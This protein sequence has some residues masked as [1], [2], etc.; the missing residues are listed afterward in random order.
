MKKSL[1]I[2][3]F[4]LTHY[5]VTSQFVQNKKADY[6][7]LMGYGYL[8]DSVNSWKYDFNYNPMQYSSKYKL[9][10]GEF[11]TANISDKLGNLIFQ[12]NNC[13]ISDAENKIIQG[14]DTLNNGI[15]YTA[16]CNPGYG[17]SPSQGTI[18]IPSMTDDTSYFMFHQRMTYYID[19]RVG[20]WGVDNLLL[21]K[22]I[23]TN[24]KYKVVFKDSTILDYKKD[25]ILI[26][27]NLTACRHANGR[28]WWLIVPKLFE[29]D[30]HVILFT[31]NGIKKSVI[32]NV[33]VSQ[34][35][36]ESGGGMSV[37]SPNGKKYIKYNADS[38][39]EIFDF[40][41][42]NGT[43]SNYKH[44]EIQDYADVYK[45]TGCAV[46]P[47]SRFLYLSSVGDIYQ[48]DLESDSIEKSKFD[49]KLDTIFA[50]T[51]Q[52]VRLRSSFWT[53]Q[54]GANG[55]IYVTCIGTRKYM[56][57]I[58]NPNLK[59][60]AC[61]LRQ[62][63]ITL[64][65]YVTRAIPFFP[66]FR[67]GAEKGSSCDTLTTALAEADVGVKGKISLY[68]NPAHDI[69]KIDMTLDEYGDLDKYTLCVVDIVGRV[70]SQY[71][72]SKFASVKEISVLGLANGLYFVQLVDGRGRVMANSKVV[73]AH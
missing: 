19:T 30:Y 1:I 12:T 17:G 13:K 59:G 63:A 49:F 69:V 71:P 34:T 65:I 36:N 4:L 70:Q 61:E 20:S 42:C 37:F 24:G 5:T 31:P 21:S 51:F 33:G 60:T 47:N 15:A 41:R 58:E 44:I 48:F 72:L 7:W 39:V 53:C 8:V 23:K 6:Q 66:N 26:D 56:H 57:V 25:S 28:D 45:R 16:M 18:I 2:L 9:L 3:G 10:N 27:G 43:F 14:G 54:L 67:L 38:D 68:P 64:P 11:M 55:K 52:G 29:R 32:K 40:D 46:S 35:V 22:V 62:N 50:D 73:V